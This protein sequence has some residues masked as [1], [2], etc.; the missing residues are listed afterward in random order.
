MPAC[1][2]PCRADSPDSPTFAMPCRAD[3]PDSPTFA[4]PC[5]ADLP[6]L[7]T[8]A[9]PCCE[10]SP[11]SPTFA[12][13]HFWEKCDS[14]R[15]IRT[16]NS[17]FWRIWGEWPLLS[18]TAF[19]LA[20]CS[21]F[22]CVHLYNCL[23]FDSLCL[24]SFNINLSFSF[25]LCLYRLIELGLVVVDV[26]ELDGD[27][28]VAEPLLLTLNAGA[29]SNLNQENN[30]FWNFQFNL[31]YLPTLNYIKYWTWSVWWL[32]PVVQPMA[33]QISI[34]AS[35]TLCWSDFWQ[36]KRIFFFFLEIT[37][38]CEFWK[39]FLSLNSFDKFR[40]CFTWNLTSLVVSKS[41]IWLLMTSP[42]TG[43]TSIR[44]PGSEADNFSNWL[45]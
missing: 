28:R 43:E 35:W 5:C 40:K 15:H 44:F 32:N 9:K 39:S 33:Y 45:T 19:V 11:D 29:G 30:W 8:F 41:K 24:S 26:D 23:S 22:S 31:F 36:K 42:L 27:G 25:A 1:A 34:F 38:L 14:P 20:S 21:I 6:N 18:F 17:P 3:S 2:E 10:D 12:K 13:G 7:P 4:E 16:S 37:S